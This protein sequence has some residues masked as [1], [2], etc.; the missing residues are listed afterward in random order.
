MDVS[1]KNILLTGSSGG[2]GTALTQVLQKSGAKLF[3][4]PPDLDLTHTQ[5]IDSFVAGFSP[6]HLDLLINC[7]GIG[8][9]KSLPELTLAEWQQSL[10]LDLTA[11]FYLTKLLLPRLLA[12]PSSMVLN[13]GSG[14]GVIP[15]KNRVAYC[16]SKFGLRGLT[17][18]LAQEYASTT[19]RFVLITL[20][21][22]LTSFG[23]KPLT[24]KQAE[25]KAG[26]AYF[27]PTWVANKLLEII[28]S[29]ASDSEY[30]LYPGDY[31]FG[32]WPKP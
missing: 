17:L 18:S 19:L 3:T 21:S 16:S 1:G 2:I 14:M 11:P 23:P 29:P 6:N 26:S 10:D 24:E 12:S 22:T 13:I 7:A 31:G 30:V 5:N 25:A 27:T 32:T 15:T 9:Y 20:G 8:I 28:S 4:L